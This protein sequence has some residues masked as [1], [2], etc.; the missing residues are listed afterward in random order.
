[1]VSNE[2]RGTGT[3][4]SANGSHSDPAAQRVSAR[5]AGASGP[6]R[7]SFCTS[8]ASLFHRLLETLPAAAY[9]CDAEGLITY[10][11]RRAAE[12]WGR[13]PQLCE[14]VDRY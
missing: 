1:M 7:P 3:P 13:A 12:V 8:E 11:N 5:P 9:T 6:G 4:T 2:F 10:F 14:P